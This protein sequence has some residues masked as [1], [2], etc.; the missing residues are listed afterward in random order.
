MSMPCIAWM[1]SIILHA[2]CTNYLVTKYTRTSLCVLSASEYCTLLIA[3]HSKA[4]KSSS[5]YRNPIQ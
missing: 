1:N 4:T 3:M 5:V 2:Y